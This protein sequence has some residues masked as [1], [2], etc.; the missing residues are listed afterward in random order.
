MDGA[1]GEGQ[2]LRGTGRP[3]RY[4]GTLGRVEQGVVAFAGEVGA[5][6][7]ERG[8]HAVVDVGGVGEGVEFAAEGGRVGEHDVG[9]G[10][11][12]E[13]EEVVE[14]HLFSRY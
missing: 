14:S 4:R 12:G 8:G 11:D 10:A 7:G 5:A 1:A 9:G 13:E 3:G 2:L 6:G